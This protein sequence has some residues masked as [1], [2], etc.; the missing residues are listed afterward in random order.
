VTGFVLQMMTVVAAGS[1]G[2][3]AKPE[4]WQHKREE[5]NNCCS[6]WRNFLIFFSSQDQRNRKRGRRSEKRVTVEFVGCRLTERTEKVRCATGA[7]RHCGSSALWGLALVLS[8]G[9]WGN[10]LARRV[11]FC[12][13]GR[14]ERKKKKSKKI[15]A[16]GQVKSRTSDQVLSAS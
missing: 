9:R 15:D 3:W 11:F 13:G 6:Q 10:L 14:R 16:Q 2:G 8:S 12:T 4:C 5:Q 1:P 7:D